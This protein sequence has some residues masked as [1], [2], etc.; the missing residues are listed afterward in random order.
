M[1]D[2]VWYVAY[3]SNMHADRLRYYLAGGRPPGAARTYP[4]CRDPRPPRRTEPVFLDGGIY[5]ALES[6]TWTG[7]MAFYDPRLPGRAAGRGYLLTAGQF[8]DIAA[9]EMARRPDADL[10][11]AEALATGSYRLGPG[12]YETLVCPGVL[13]GHPMLTFTAP[14]AC[15]DVE[16]TPPAPR[17]LGMIASGLHEAHGWDAETLTAYLADRPGVRGHWDPDAVADR[18]ARIEFRWAHTSG[19]GVTAPD[20]S[21]PNSNCQRA[22]R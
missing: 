20:D 19:G 3:G 8:A 6:R 2:L 15:A 12:R 7:G 18:V 5:F 4:G 11:L 22:I 17:Y 21:E 9:Q 16:P 1:T 14:W 13:D 10:D